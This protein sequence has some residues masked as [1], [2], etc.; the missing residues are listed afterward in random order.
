MKRKIIEIDEDLCNGCAACIPNCPEGALQIIDKKAR[1]ISDLFCDGLGACIGHCPQGAI[2]IVE[3]EAEKY[4]EKKVMVNITRQGKN[5][6]VAHLKH[7]KDHGESELY[8]QAID[9]LSEKGIE[10]P[11]DEEKSALNH[12][13]KTHCACPGSKEVNQFGIKPVDLAGSAKGGVLAVSELR[14][15]PIQLHLVSENASFFRDSDLLISADCVGFSDPNFHRNMLRHHALAVC[16]PKLDDTEIYPEKIRAII[17]N[18]DPRSITVAIMEVPC[19]SRL[20]SMVENA[21]RETGKDIPLKKV[22]LKI[23]GSYA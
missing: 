19:C 4:D 9:Y 13:P 11:F 15:W 7:L 2:T 3:R 1:L 6:I 20:Y 12:I 18:N 17:E 14:Q 22:V 5:T 21:L 16:C 10:N 23:N 8:G